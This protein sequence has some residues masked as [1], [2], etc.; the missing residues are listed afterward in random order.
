MGLN[1]GGDQGG[2]DGGLEEV[3]EPAEGNLEH[4]LP[5]HIRGD[6]H[7]SY[8]FPFNL[9]DELGQ[10]PAEVI[11]FI[12]DD[13]LVLL[14]S[15]REEARDEVTADEDQV[16]QEPEDA[17]AVEPAGIGSEA[18]E[19]VEVAGAHHRVEGVAGNA[20]DGPEVQVQGQQPANQ[21]EEEGEGEENG[22]LHAMTEAARVAL[23]D[24]QK[25]STE[26]QTAATALVR[27][28]RR[29]AERALAAAEAAAPFV[30]PGNRGGGRGRGRGLVGRAL[31]RGG[32]RRAEGL[33]DQVPG[34]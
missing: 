27:I 10:T 26:L 15:G 5:E 18:T 30:P 32:R 19:I 14:D 13:M 4:Q 33:G 16:M 24:F 21:A 34:G 12:I 25:A 23:A 20:D 1:N 29:R 3:A 7:L 28:R 8:D 2:Q 11:Q 31:G 6:L 9:P 22:S 17:D